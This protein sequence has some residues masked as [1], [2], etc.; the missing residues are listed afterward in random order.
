M[1]QTVGFLKSAR[2]L[3]REMALGLLVATAVHALLL[4]TGQRQLPTL[5]RRAAVVRLAESSD[6]ETDAPPSA[7]PEPARS[8]ADFQAE[9]AEAKEAAEAAALASPEPFT[10]EGGGFSPVALVTVV[11]FIIGG[12]LFFQ[13]ISGGG[14]A[15]LFSDGESAEVQACIKKAATRNEASACLPPVP[16]GAGASPIIGR[17]PEI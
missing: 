16:T 10:L 17:A 9:Q 12:A 14:A 1:K 8:A 11:V 2:N 4:P 6:T 13:G 7:W 3:C 5:Q 15:N